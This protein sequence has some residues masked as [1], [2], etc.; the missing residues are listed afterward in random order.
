M[1]GTAPVT[2]KRVE[3]HAFN[4]PD[5][6]HPDVSDIVLGLWTQCE[7]DEDADAGSSTGKKKKSGEDTRER[8]G[9]VE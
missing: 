9:S 1:Q 7:E 3:H 8:L 6:P 4:H 5:S 2:V